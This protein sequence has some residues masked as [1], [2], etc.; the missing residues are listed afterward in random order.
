MALAAV[1]LLFNLLPFSHLSRR[2][3]R[4]YIP[5]PVFHLHPFHMRS[6]GRSPTKLW[7]ATNAGPESFHHVE[8]LDTQDQEQFI[9]KMEEES[10]RQSQL[11]QTIF[12]YVGVFAMIMSLVFYPFVCQE[13]CSIRFGS[14]LI[15]AIVSCGTH[16][17]S[18]KISRSMTKSMNGHGNSHESESRLPQSATAVA[19]LGTTPILLLLVVVWVVA[20]LA[21]LLL[22]VFGSFHEDLEHFHIGLTIGN[23]VTMMGTVILLWDAH[24][25]CEA[26]TDLYGAKYEHKSL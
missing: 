23:F 10:R 19:G 3:T 2:F 13:E 15:H 14:C 16:A 12:E 25:T 11:F 6:R 26:F 7:Q 21:P 1:C 9:Q 24:T 5:P 20:H 4:R 8:I 18:I 22:W 17:L